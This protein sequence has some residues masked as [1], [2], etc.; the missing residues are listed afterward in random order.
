M[1]NNDEEGAEITL[2]SEINPAMKNPK[3][4]ILLYLEGI[5]FMAHYRNFIFRKSINFNGGK[6]K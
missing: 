4:T 3:N 1:S 5:L 2:E 6:T